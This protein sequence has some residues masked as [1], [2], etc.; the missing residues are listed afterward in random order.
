MG[1]VQDKLHFYVIPAVHL[2]CRY[3]G[4]RPQASLGSNADDWVQK[5]V[6]I[7]HRNV[8]AN[9]LQIATYEKPFRQKLKAPGSKDDFTDVVLGL[10]P[11]SH[12]YALVIICH[13][14]V[15]RGDQVINLPKFDMDQFLNAISR[16]EI[17][18]LYLVTLTLICS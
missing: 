6:M 10:L 15:Y 1:K 4:L 18:L 8:I 9:I 12:I 14:S 17:G 3:V 11:Q 13:A 16:Y 5:G 7:S 2:V